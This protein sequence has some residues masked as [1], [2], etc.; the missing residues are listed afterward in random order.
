MARHHRLIASL[1]AVVLIGAVAA[2]YAE[3]GRR[4]QQRLDARASALTR[5]DPSR[6]AAAI[7]H[8]GCGGCHTIPGITGARGRVGPPLTGVGQRA[9]IAGQQRNT[10]D[11]LVAWIRYPR[12]V[13][14]HTAMPE[15]G[16]SERDAR[17]IAAY[18]YARGE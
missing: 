16:V 15:L 4:H 7:G 8:Y 1:C 11:N 17:D 10:P 5:G 14:P 9:Y 13:A 3:L 2:G 12:H 18:L 6:G